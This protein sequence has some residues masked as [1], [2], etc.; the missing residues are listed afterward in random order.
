MAEYFLDLAGYVLEQRARAMEPNDLAKELLR[1]ARRKVLPERLRSAA[2]RMNRMNW[3]I[4]G[5][6]LQLLGSGL[7]TEGGLT[8]V[9]Y[10]SF[11][12]RTKIRPDWLGRTGWLNA[13][14]KTLLAYGKPLGFRDLFDRI[15]ADANF[16]FN[17]G[18]P[19]W[20]LYNNLTRGRGSEL[21]SQDGEFRIAVEAVSPEEPPRIIK[22]IKRPPADAP[23]IAQKIHEANLEAIIAEDL[24]RVEDGLTLV[25]RQYTAPPVGRIDLLCRDRKGDFVVIEIKRFHASTESI[26]DQVTRY[27][28]WVEEHLAHAGQRVRGVIVVGKPDTSLTYSIRAVPNLSIMCLDVSLTPYNPSS[29][30]IVTGVRHR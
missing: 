11:R 2:S 15:V 3:S 18:G 1:L 27:M 4:S 16:R 8:V 22:A 7:A 13:A 14:F 26:I 24:N 9:E 21:F 10:P 6:S 30:R 23:S 19:Q 17:P 12:L 20:Q 28:G 5:L 29:R 25:G